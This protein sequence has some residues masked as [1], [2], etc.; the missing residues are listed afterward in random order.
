MFPASLVCTTREDICGLTPGVMLN[1]LNVPPTPPHRPS[2]LLMLLMNSDA[3][4][5]CRE[6][7]E[8]D[9]GI[10]GSYN[11]TISSEILNVPRLASPLAV[12][13]RTLSLGDD[14]SVT[15]IVTS[16]PLPSGNTRCRCG[17]GGGRVSDYF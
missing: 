13:R 17:G 8:T 1:G 7:E 6:S 12:T 5:S 3:S 4:L 16:L 14:C 15:S 9:A 2:L 10:N 11:P